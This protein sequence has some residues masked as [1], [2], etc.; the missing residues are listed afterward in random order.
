MLIH[1]II[2]VG[3]PME[4]GGHYGAITIGEPNK[5][6]LEACRLLG[7]RVAKLATKLAA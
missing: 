1:A 2:I 3:D 6:A 4:T 5:K 7:L